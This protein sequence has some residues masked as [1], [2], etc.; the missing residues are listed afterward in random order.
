MRVART[1][2]SHN[3]GVGT[4]RVFKVTAVLQEIEAW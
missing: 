1:E 4:C 3:T 2:E